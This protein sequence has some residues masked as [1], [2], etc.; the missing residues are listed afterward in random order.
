[1]SDYNHA[2]EVI[3]KDGFP[4]K[5]V[6]FGLGIGTQFF[7]DSCEEVT[8]IELFTSDN[9]LAGELRISNDSWM[10]HFRK[11]FSGYKNWRVIGFEVGEDIIRAERDIVGL[12]GMPRGSDP[13][14]KEYRKELKKMVDM[15]VK[16]KGFEYAF[17]DAGSHL[18]GDIVNELFG[19]VPIISIHDSK[20]KEKVYGCH[21]INVPDNYRVVEGEK[22]AEGIRF[23]IKSG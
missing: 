13:S 2:H 1:M 18:R 6:E 15:L 20:D 17:V 4:K 21:R 10:P 23:F 5:M 9:E 22:C 8:S 7:I 11:I 3:F 16:G 19:V 12:T 14:D